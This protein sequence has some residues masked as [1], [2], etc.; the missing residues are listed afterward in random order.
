MCL[1]LILSL[2][3]GTLAYIKAKKAI[4]DS[5]GITAL[6]IRRAISSKVDLEKFSKLVREEDM[7]SEYYLFFRNQ[8][9]ELKISAGLKYLYTWR[10]TLQGQCM[11]IVDGA[12][13][14]DENTSLLGDVE[15]DVTK[16]AENTFNGYEGQDINW[17][18]EWGDLISVYIPL[19]DKDGKIYGMI[20][21]DFESSKIITHLNQLKITIGIITFLVIGMGG[22]SLSVSR[23]LVKSIKRINQQIETIRQGSLEVNIDASSSDEIGDLSRGFVVMVANL[24]DIT[25]DIY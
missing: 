1:V 24:K 25:H 21:A 8:L 6:N 14:D 4:E 7:K 16:T 13:M 12:S 20:A 5:I 18:K 11:Y 17:T 10:R 9:N 3:I 23:I 22:L 15:E 2:L 19:K